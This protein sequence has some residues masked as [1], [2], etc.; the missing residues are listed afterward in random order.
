MLPIAIRRAI[1]DGLLANDIVGFHARRWR[2]TSCASR[3][4]FV[5]VV[6]DW[7]RDSLG[8]DGRRVPVTAEPIS[9]DPAEFDELALERGGA[10]RG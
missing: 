2:G 6:P 7:A 8:Y 10:R 4:D 5:G 9:V 1:H 3:A